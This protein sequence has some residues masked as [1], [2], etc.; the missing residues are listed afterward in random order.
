MGTYFRFSGE[1]RYIFV[2]NISR[3]LKKLLNFGGIR[4]LY[5]LTVIESLQYS[6]KNLHRIELTSAPTDPNGNSIRIR[7]WKLLQNHTTFKTLIIKI[8]VFVNS[9]PK[10]SGISR[11]IKVNKIRNIFNFNWKA[12]VNQKDIKSETISSCKFH[13]FS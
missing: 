10:K 3:F 2:W 7:I 11:L 4:R 12:V 5:F 8:H 6:K 1:E 9:D 13:Y